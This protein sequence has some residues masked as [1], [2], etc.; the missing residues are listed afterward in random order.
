MYITKFNFN[1]VHFLFCL[2]FLLMFTKR[3]NIYNKKSYQYIVYLY[4]NRY[5]LITTPTADWNMNYTKECPPKLIYSPEPH[6]LMIR[7]T[8]VSH[9]TL[10]QM[11]LGSTNLA[12]FYVTMINENICFKARHSITIQ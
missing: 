10:L 9:I 12:H 5:S 8:V 11:P 7:F 4:N 6:L 3:C 1:S 2:I